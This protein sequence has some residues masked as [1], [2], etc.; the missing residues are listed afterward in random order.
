LAIEQHDLECQ[1]LLRFDEFL[2]FH[3]KATTIN[4]IGQGMQEHV[5][6]SFYCPKIIEKFEL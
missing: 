6:L 2:T 5:F 4:N 1:Y 3:L